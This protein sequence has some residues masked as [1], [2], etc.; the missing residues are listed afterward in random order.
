M[1]KFIKSCLARGMRVPVKSGGHF[2]PHE[3]SE[4]AE[5]H[6]YQHQSPQPEH[7]SNSDS[8]LQLSAVILPQHS[9]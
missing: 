9:Y 5:S 1:T 6:A 4:S 8:S 3:I 2:L 7:G